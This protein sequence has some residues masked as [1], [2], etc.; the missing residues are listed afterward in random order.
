[1]TAIIRLY[2]VP[3]SIAMFCTLA[4]KSDF[5]GFPEIPEGEAI[6]V[7]NNEIRQSNARISLDTFNDLTLSANFPDEEGSINSVWIGTILRNFDLQESNWDDLDL[8][9]ERVIELDIFHRYYPSET[10]SYA[11]VFS[12][13]TDS[14]IIKI[15]VV[16]TFIKDERLDFILPDRYIGDEFPNRLDCT[17]FF[18][19][20]LE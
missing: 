20:K 6:L 3:L 10:K 15:E 16:S 11:K 17:A 18:H 13:N 1:M 2:L 4:C 8:L 14:R 19:V 7:F 12:W 9:F 5:D